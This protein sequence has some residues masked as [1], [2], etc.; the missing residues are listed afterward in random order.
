MVTLHYYPSNANAAPH[1]L[2]EEFG[3]D[4]DL[5]L[6][7]RTTNAQKSPEYLKINPNGRIPTLIDGDHSI[8]E[9]A[10]IMMHLVDKYPEKG[11]A[12]A[13]GTPERGH[14]YQWMC[15]LTN[16]VQEDLMS[17]FYPERL[18]GEEEGVRELIKAG[19]EKRVSQHFDV[20]EQ[21]LQAQGP[22]FLG[23]KI[24]AVDL[25]F[26]MIARWSRG[27][28]PAPRSRVHV[29]K[30]IDLIINRDAVKQAYAD[31]GIHEKIA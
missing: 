17:W 21:H 6:V 29:S 23:D 18:V 10:A 14:F 2:L 28:S 11:F 12:P 4:Y 16:S 30:L 19:A 25:F 8:F 31:E 27:I 26:T 9:S 22:Y 7:D 13:M 5:V 15:F 1:M 3:V 20:I 24:S